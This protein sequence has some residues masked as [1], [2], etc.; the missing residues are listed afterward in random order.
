MTRTSARFTTSSARK[1]S[2]E[3][4]LLPVPVGLELGDSQVSAASLEVRRTRSPRE[5]LE[6]EEGDSARLTPTRYS[7]TYIPS[8]SIR[9][10]ESL[11]V[12]TGSS[13][14]ASEEWEAALE[15]CGVWAVWA[16]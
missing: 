6:A 13:S 1:V 16:V 8:T 3:E 12:V 15:A 5:A 9:I 14:A 11:T 2:K 10:G 7:S 4:V